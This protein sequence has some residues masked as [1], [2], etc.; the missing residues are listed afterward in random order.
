LWRRL[1]SLA[2]V[3]FLVTLLT[4]WIMELLP[5]STAEAVLG[6]SAT[7]ENIQRVREDLHL[8]DS[9][10][11]RYTTWLG[12]AVRGDLGV[13]YPDGRVVSVVL[14]EGLPA[15]MEILVLTQLFAIGVA[16]PAAMAAA[17]REGSRLDRNLS[18][19]S[20]VALAMPQLAFGIVLLTVFAQKLRWF[21]AS[22][23]THL[24]ESV[25]G[26]LRAMVLPVLTLGLPFA[27]VYFRVLRADIVNTLRSDHIAFARGMGLSS[28]RIMWRRALRPSSLTLISVA[29]LNTALLLG[30]VAIVE[31]IYGVPGLG[32]TLIISVLSRQ[33][34]L[35]QG[36]VLVIAVFYVL[37]NLL[38]D[39]A[40]TVLD[41]RVRL[42]RAAA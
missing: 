29:G 10:V 21:P 25:G 41:P 20:F 14:R 40:L 30:G 8:D 6:P 4:F 31:N 36:C 13:T 9:F 22:E 11:S 15:S 5:G 19:G 26:N 38:V 3:M 37:M 7:P 17:R 16:L 42:E 24:T 1:V 23:Y 35:V 28:S 12:R 34:T 2:V 33:I 32:R 39:V 18:S 27:G